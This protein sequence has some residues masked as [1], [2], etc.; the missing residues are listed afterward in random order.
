MPKTLLTLLALMLLA[1]P[2]FAKD[3][4]ID[5][6]TAAGLELTADRVADE[7]KPAL[8]F[9]AAVDKLVATDETTEKGKFTR[10]EVEGWYESDAIGAPAL[11]VMNRL[12]EIPAGA[13]LKVNILSAEAKEYSAEELGIAH[14]I[15]PK[16]PPRPKTGEVPFAYE[17]AAYMHKGFQQFDPVE[18]IDLGNARNLRVA[19]VRFFPVAY[20]PAENRFRVT[21]K[22]SFELVLEGADAHGAMRSGDL[23]SPAFD[24]L[25]D[26]IVRPASLVP[27]VTRS[28][29]NKVAYL[30]ITDKMFVDA[31]KPFVEHKKKRGYLV[32]VVSTE[33]FGADV[34]NG[35]KALIHDR[36]NSPTPN[37]PAPSFVLFVGDHE[38]IPAFKGTTGSHITDLPYVA[39]TP[40]DNIPDILAG[41]FSA[42]NVDEL[43]PQIEKTI[44]YENNQTA[45][46]KQRAVLIAGWDSRFTR[47][48]GWT[49]INY[50]TKYYFNEKFGVTP[51]V[52]LSAGSHQND[53]DIVAKVAAGASFVNYTAHGSPT[54]WGDP[55]FQI[56]DINALGNKGMYPVV[57]GNCCLT[58]KFEIGTCF[59]E[60]WLRAKDQGAVS[61]IGG[62][63]STYW[64]EDLWWGVGL[65]PVQ[66]PN[67]EGV[68]PAI[69]KTGVGAYDAVFSGKAKSAGAM[70]LA[71]LMAVEQS[72]SSRK[73]YYWEIYQIMG[74]PALAIKVG[75]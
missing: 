53:K 55:S 45:A 22:V 67:N 39:I 7:T 72:N 13:T 31:L 1:T 36:Y 70:T 3:I 5:G 51:N 18:A 2:C 16:Q 15:Y 44:F 62:T 74:D 61:Y 69:E 34:Q 27:D 33:Q 68:P 11:P 37:A 56:S 26:A 32:E 71:G 10:L 4:P 24:F 42:R 20:N 60:A 12:V 28:R 48:H 50:G 65:Y 46:Y 64:D 40:G 23:E 14:P 49:Q 38:Q 19:M 8:E 58:N 29:K 59:G 17:E 21:S 9:T 41:R 47:S 75:K 57:V 35:V 25:N 54:S 6:K 73:K 43:L 30:I 52:Y 63:N 66:L